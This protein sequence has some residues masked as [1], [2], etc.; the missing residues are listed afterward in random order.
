MLPI[1]ELCCFYFATKRGIGYWRFQRSSTFALVCLFVEAITNL[2]RAVYCIVDPFLSQ[3]IFSFQVHRMLVTVTF[4]WS[5]GTSLL[6]ALYWAESITRLTPVRIGFLSRYKVHFIAI[7]VLFILLELFG[8][9]VHAF[10]LTFIRISIVFAVSTAG[11]CAQLL[12][13][14]LFLY[15]GSKVLKFLRMD[16]E[17]I[18][19]NTD[20]HRSRLR[21]MTNRIIVSGIGMIVFIVSAAFGGTSLFNTPYGYFSIFAG[22]YLGLQITSIMQIFAFVKPQSKSAIVPVEQENT[23]SSAIWATKPPS[24]SIMHAKPVLPVS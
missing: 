1:F 5:V 21:R 4:P 16:V 24:A 17:L 6:I 10:R 18:A 3:N 7:L 2:V 13:A 15:Y 8:S 22:A 12:V 9:I 19:T 23:V 11:V 14:L 20:M